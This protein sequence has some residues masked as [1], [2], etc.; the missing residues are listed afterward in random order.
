MPDKH[1]I[2]VKPCGDGWT[3]ECDEVGQ[4]ILFITGGRA[5]HH[6]RAMA[7]AMAKA[8]CDVRLLICDRKGDVVAIGRHF[9]MRPDGVWISVV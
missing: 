2:R 4:P 8:G 6:A 7:A 1:Q 9:S 5:E 3:V